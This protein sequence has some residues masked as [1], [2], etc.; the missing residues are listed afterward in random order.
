MQ[1][2]ANK[3]LKFANGISEKSAFLLTISSDWMNCDPQNVAL[4]F[5]G[6]GV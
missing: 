4:F 3:F 1:K 5:M 6:I 2:N